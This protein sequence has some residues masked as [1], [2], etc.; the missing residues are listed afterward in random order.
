MEIQEIFLQATVYCG[1]P[2]AGGA[3]KVA[4]EVFE[5]PEFAAM[6]GTLPP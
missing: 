1:V 2:T 6:G 4:R 3:F 5:E